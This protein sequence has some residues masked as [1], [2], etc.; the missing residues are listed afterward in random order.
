M[1]ERI[2][3]AINAFMELCRKE[4]PPDVTKTLTIIHLLISKGESVEGVAR[5][6]GVDQRRVDAAMRKISRLFE[7]IKAAKEKEK[8]TALPK[9]GKKG[10]KKIKLFISSPKARKMVFDFSPEKKAETERFMESIWSKQECEAMSRFFVDTLSAEETADI[11]D[12]TP[13]KLHSIENEA[14]RK[15]AVKLKEM[16][17][18]LEKMKLQ[19]T[20]ARKV[21]KVKIKKAKARKLTPRKIPFGKRAI[22]KAQ[23]SEKETTFLVLYRKDVY[24]KEIASDL[25]IPT[26]SICAFRKVLFSKIEKANQKPKKDPKKTGRSKGEKGEIRKLNFDTQ[27]IDRARLGKRQKSIFELYHDESRYWTVKE[28]AEKFEVT[29]STICGTYSVAI[30][31]LERAQQEIEIEKAQKAKK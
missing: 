28:M 26:G 10:F 3:K 29:P 24:L 4:F 13:R 5:L 7:G 12:V 6:I 11:L 22:A 20:K 14:F 17:I 18:D 27:I 30:K 31:K 8:S 2:E 19:K 23:L 15:L 21:K 1:N 25:G 16:E 9:L